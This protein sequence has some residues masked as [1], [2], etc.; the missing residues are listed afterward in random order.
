[1]QRYRPL[2]LELKLSDTLSSRLRE[3]REFRE[4]SIYEV[5]KLCRFKVQRI[6]DLEAGMESWLSA[7]DRQRIAKALAVEPV[8]LKEVEIR[9]QLE[10]DS[11]F[12]KANN[13]ILSLA[14]LSGKKDLVCPD[15]GGKLSSSVENALD[16][17]GVPFRFAKA[18]CQDCTFL[19]R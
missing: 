12:T 15:C 7:S 10:E 6:E 8:L 9:P 3:I 16:H 5:A 17:E 13:R 2:P 14:I 1:M 19:L 18:F 4:L 11:A